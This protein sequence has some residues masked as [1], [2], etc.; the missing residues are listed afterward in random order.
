MPPTVLLL[1]PRG[2]GRNA[3][4]LR[5][6]GLHVV[7]VRDPQAADAS[8]WLHQPSVIVARLDARTREQYLAWCRSHRTLQDGKHIPIVFTTER[9]S[10]DDMR[11]TLDPGALVLAVRPAD[12]AKVVA[13]IR[14]VL[15]VISD[16]P[17]S[18]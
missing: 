11:L 16:A 3:H 8:L 9:I 14:G 15:A 10:Q 7:E 4:D 18:A 1:D 12:G 13:A 2:G 17:K 5:S 6:A